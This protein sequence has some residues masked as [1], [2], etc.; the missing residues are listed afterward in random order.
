MQY[1]V[2]FS[3][4]LLIVVL[5]TTILPDIFG[6]LGFYD[7]IIP[8]VIYFSLYR[9]FREGFSSLILAAVMMDM[10]S[11]APAGIYLTTY[12]WLFLAFRQTWRF[13]DLKYSYLFP[14]LV[15]IGVV[16]QQIL[17]G[18]VITVQAGQLGFSGDAMQVVFFQL[19]WAV[20]TAPLIF[21]FLRVFFAFTDRVFRK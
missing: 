6:S 15:V 18:V 5:Q 10:I 16:F 17:F 1:L 4:S 11:G 7:L 14:V 19:L 21:L 3:F 2:F 8:L 12:I 13:L 9:P 20:I